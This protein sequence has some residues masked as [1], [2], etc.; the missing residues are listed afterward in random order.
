MP[1]YMDPNEGGE[2][3]ADKPMADK[4][5][6]DG[7]ETSL[8]PKSFFGKAGDLEPGA[9]CCVKIVA[10]HGD[11]IEVEYCKKDES[12]DENSNAPEDSGD[13]QSAMSGLDAMAK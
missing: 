11:E 10:I 7:A 8:L 12:K 1:D 6:D 4:P 5:Q 9:E 2:T 13:M 3:S